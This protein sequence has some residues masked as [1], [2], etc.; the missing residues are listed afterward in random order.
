MKYLVIAVDDS[1]FI[2]KIIDNFLDPKLFDVHFFTSADDAKK[3]MDALPYQGREVDLVLLDI[4]LQD[5]NKEESL[6]L[7]DFLTKERK[8]TQVIVMSGRLSAAE[9]AEF[10]YKGADSYLLK[11]FSEDNFISS[12]K[13]HIHIARTLPKYNNRPLAK[14]KVS[15]RDVFISHVAATEKIASIFRDELMK[16]DIGSWCEKAELLDD[17]IW[18]AVLLEAIN[19]CKIFILILTHNSLKSDYIKQEIIQAFNRKKRDGNRFFIIPVLFNVQ[20]DEIP[21]QLSSMHCVDITPADK[22]AD[23]IRS[24]MFSI[25]KAVKPRG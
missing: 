3:A 8:R 10:Y 20:L 25:E 4:Y 2:H 23:N 7:L 21:R 17:D 5:G 22:R 13:R 1:K 15:K 9:F 11:P 24:L 14:V 18:R 19:T 16:S 12:V 6:G